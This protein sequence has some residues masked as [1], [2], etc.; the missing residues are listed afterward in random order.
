MFKKF[1]TKFTIFF[2]FLYFTNIF[3]IYSLLT[4]IIFRFNFYFKL[5]INLIY[6]IIITIIFSLLIYLKIDFFSKKFQNSSYL[7]LI[8][9]YFLE[10]KDKMYQIIYTYLSINFTL[11][12]KAWIFFGL[13]NFFS[14]FF[15]FICTK[16][17]FYSF[18][19]FF[20]FF[21]FLIYNLLTLSEKYVITNFFKKDD[22]ID[23]LNIQKK[24]KIKNNILLNKNFQYIHYRYFTIPN[25]P[26]VREKTKEIIQM[27]IGTG[28]IGSMVGFGAD[29][30]HKDKDREQSQKQFEE[31]KEQ[32]QKQF[33]K[34][35]EQ[36]QK[37]FEEKHVGDSFNKCKEQE[38]KHSVSL[39]K[40]KDSQGFFNPNKNQIELEEKKIEEAKACSNY[41]DEIAKKKGIKLPSSDTSNIDDFF[42]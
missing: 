23:Y 41:W 3:Y 12:E 30:Y 19:N 1:I 35:Q 24:L 14:L 32:S 15:Y 34:S 9:Y 8:F 18:F 25:N 7:N 27:V 39:T 2:N 20:L 16:L 11:L 6:L 36:L 22:I 13:I 28:V 26:V 33:E 38:Y 37:Q 42:S 5:N 40:L 29:K 17:L 4:I 10:F 31:N 21:S